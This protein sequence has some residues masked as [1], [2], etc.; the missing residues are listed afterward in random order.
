MVQRLRIIFFANFCLCTAFQFAWLA[1]GCAHSLPIR[2][3]FLLF[4]SGRGEPAWTGIF[5]GPALLAGYFASRPD[6][7]RLARLSAAVLG[8]RSLLWALGVR[9][10]LSTIYDA[11]PFVFN[12]ETAVGIYILVSQVG[13]AVF[14]KARG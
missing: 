12:F 5:I 8:V 4:E 7:N 1:Y 11:H 9:Y 10:L 3:K 2:E 14:W 13:L 6:L